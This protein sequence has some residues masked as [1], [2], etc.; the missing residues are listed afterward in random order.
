MVITEISS[1]LLQFVLLCIHIAIQISF[2]ASTSTFLMTFN[3]EQ[4]R[5]KRVRNEDAEQPIA[6]RRCINKPGLPPIPSVL[7]YA[8]QG[9][10]RYWNSLMANEEIREWV[11]GF[12]D[13]AFCYEDVQLFWIEC[14]EI[15][16]SKYC[17]ES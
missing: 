3:N 16:H 10:K 12:F 11:F 13:D 8:L 7:D 9:T 6:K 5:N 2:Q 1:D 14:L 15:I 4:N 17:I